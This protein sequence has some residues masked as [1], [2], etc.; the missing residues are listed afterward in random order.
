MSYNCG[1]SLKNPSF[2]NIF[3]HPQYILKYTEDEEFIDSFLKSNVIDRSNQFTSCVI[4]NYHR[5]YDIIMSVL[6]Y[7]YR[8][9]LDITFDSYCDISNDIRKNIKK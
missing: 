5:N 2:G 9:G 3:V 4:L 1:K 7:F 6:A 8:L